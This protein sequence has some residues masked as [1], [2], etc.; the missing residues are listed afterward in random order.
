MRIKCEIVLE[1][2]QQLSLN[3]SS[4][5]KIW[6]VNQ[7]MHNSSRMRHV[8]IKEKDVMM[9]FIVLMTINVALLMGW[10]L[11]DP[12]MW[13][14]TKPENHQSYGYCSSEGRASIGFLV[15]IAIVNVSALVL[16]NVQAFRARNI[17][18]EYSE[19]LYVFITMMSLLQ[20]LFIGIPLIVLSNEIPV[21]K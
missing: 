11:V 14:R 7:V 15:S 4:S 21:G 17:A 18:T 6:R 16:A 9:P 8:T 13:H 19:S 1:L 3:L 12:M 5:S 20:A 2:S 10:T